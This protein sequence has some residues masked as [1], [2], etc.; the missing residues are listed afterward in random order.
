MRDIIDHELDIKC[1]V[2]Q[3]NFN[4][5]KTFNHE[6]NSSLDKMPA[7]EPSKAG[8]KFDKGK[9]RYS[10]LPNDAIQDIVRVL[11]KGADKYGDRNWEGG[12]DFSR[13]YDA[14]KRHLD[15]W[16]DHEDNDPED[17]LSHLSH[18]ACNLL[19]LIHYTKHM[20]RFPASE[21]Y[22]YDDRPY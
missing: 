6:M 7:D 15:A 19:F 5:P 14:I 20:D 16:W 2:I 17:N 1:G 3:G 4:Q 8:V 18:A 10:L 13:L 11:M 22:L 12:L 21:Y 9:L